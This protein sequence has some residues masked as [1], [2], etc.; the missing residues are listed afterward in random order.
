MMLARLHPTPIAACGDIHEKQLAIVIKRRSEVCSHVWYK[1]LR[2]YECANYPSLPGPSDGLSNIPMF[3][4]T[5]WKAPVDPIILLDRL[6]QQYTD[7]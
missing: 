3:W 2:S 5:S 7:K 6:S 4:G 1:K